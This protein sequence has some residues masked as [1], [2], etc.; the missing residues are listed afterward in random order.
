MRKKRIFTCALAPLLAAAFLFRPATAEGAIIINHLTT[1][2]SKV[3]PARITQA[4]TLLRVAY[5]H[6]SHGSQLV[7]GL[8][9]L[10]GYYGE[11]SV[12]AYASSYGYDAGVFFNDYAI[13]GAEDL[14]NPN[15][16]DW[17]AATR[18]FLNR[19]GGCN[20]NVIMWS[21]CGQ[22]SGAEESDITNYLSKMNALETEFPDVQFVYIT[23]HLDGSGIEGN[24]NQRNE[25]IRAYCLANDKILFDFADIES[26]D[27]GGNYYLDQ[28]ADDGCNYS[29]GNWARE[30]RIANPE[31]ELTKIANPVCNDSCCAHTNSLNCVMKGRALWW[32][33]A[34]LAG[35]AGSDEE[36]S[37]TVASPN[38]GETWVAGSTH[39]IKWQSTGMVFNVKLEYSSNAGGAWTTIAGSAAN[40]GKYVWTVPAGL[41]ATGLIRVTDVL[42]GAVTDT[43]DAVFSIVP[44]IPIIGLSKT[45]IHFA[46]VKKGKMTPADSVL[47][48]NPGGGVMRWTASSSEAWLALTPKTG[49]A[50]REM[51]IKIVK[52]NG[53]AEG[54]YPAVITVADPTAANSPQIINVTLTVMAEGTDAPPFGEFETPA[55]GATITTATVA[56]TGWALDDVGMKS[57]KIYRRV[58]ATKRVLLGTGRFIAGARPDIEA[59]HELYPRKDRAGWSFTLKMKKLPNHGVGTYVLLVYVRDLAG[60]EVLLGAHTITGPA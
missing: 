51:K 32:L 36:P 54:T 2:L 28:G 24:L 6:T 5:Q 40:S 56:V 34:R 3:P 47:I 20:R 19:P 1:D 41:T 29:G 30:W 53:L 25:Q 42:D 33:F 55:D 48:S 21:W 15:F 37:L 22:V 31:N 26:Y 11:E 44:D 7:T 49:A 39:P 35:W 9:A 8:E 4:Q 57:V 16:N 17:Y 52:A 46:K 14:G 59:E 10:A 60:H 27:P 13:P 58:S 18:N 38:G 12:Y 45:D 43:S 50:G 23:G